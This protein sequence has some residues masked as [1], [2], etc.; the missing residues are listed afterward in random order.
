M[1]NIM[2]LSNC[3][4]LLCQKPLHCMAS[5]LRELVIGNVEFILTAGYKKNT[6]EVEILGEILENSKS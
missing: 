3:T 5:M 2:N 1:L 4:V 6:L